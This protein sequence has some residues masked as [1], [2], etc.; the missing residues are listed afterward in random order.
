MLMTDNRCTYQ[1]LQKDFNIVSAVIHKIIHEE[2][3]T[4]KVVCRWVPH[5][6][7]E[8][9]KVERVRIS[10]ETLQLLND[11]GHRI[12]SKIVTS[13]ETYIPFF[14][15]PTRQ[16]SKVWVFEDDPTPTMVKRQL[17]M[18]KAMH[19]IFSNFSW[20]KPST[21]RQKRSP[22]SGG[23]YWFKKIPLDLSPNY[24]TK[25]TEE[26]LTTKYLTCVSPLHG[27]SSVTLGLEL[28]TH[29]P[30]AR[31]HDHWAS[32][33]SVVCMCGDRDVYSSV[34][35]ALDGGSKLQCLL[36]VTFKYYAKLD[37]SQRGAIK[38]RWISST[39]DEEKSFKDS[40][41]LQLPRILRTI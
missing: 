37:R 26:H 2:L 12:I 32:M 39:R 8:Q 6:Q 7:T 38:S 20:S 24:I 36:L 16:E 28:M 3:H 1:I 5:N 18:E 35:L 29:W 30:Q 19:A 17:A 40:S 25:P 15:V 11:N 34:F 9:Q 22:L 4:K 27:G 41:V 14:D 13:D 10:K 33:A 21:I 31:D 23:C